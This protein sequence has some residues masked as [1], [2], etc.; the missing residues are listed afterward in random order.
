MAKLIN[1]IQPNENEELETEDKIIDLIKKAE[2][3]EKFRMEG[4]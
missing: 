2:Q 4:L 1:R 3:G